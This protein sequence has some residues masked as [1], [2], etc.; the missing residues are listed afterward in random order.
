MQCKVSLAEK[1]TLNNDCREDTNEETAGRGYE[2]SDSGA[3][4]WSVDSLY[5]LIIVTVSIISFCLNK[6]HNKVCYLKDLKNSDVIFI[7]I[8]SS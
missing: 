5:K 6:I 3:S 8:Q 1:H 2:R 4:W 7:I